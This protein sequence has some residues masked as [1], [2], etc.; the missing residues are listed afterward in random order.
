MTKWLG[1]VAI[2]VLA[3]LAELS[4][5]RLSG[6][7][8]FALFFGRFHPLIVHLPIGFFLLVA[9]GEAATLHPK[10]RQRVEPALGL[11]VPVSALAALAAF[12]MGQL[13]ALEG[14]FPASA[15]GWHR[16]L[17]LLAVIGMS[18]C[19][20]LFDRQ[21]DK[22]GQGRGAYRGV[23]GL[24]LGLLSLGAHFG[25]TMTRGESYLS[26]YAPGPL[27]PL[28]G[29]PEAKKEASGAKP[30]A[31]AAGAE[32]LVYQDVVQPLLTKYC[33]DCH[34]S[35]K[36]KGKLRLDSLE[37]LMAG[38]E[39]GAVV[40][41]GAPSKSLLVTR[42]LLPVADDDHMPPKDEPSPPPEAIALIQ[43]WIERGASA[44]LKVRDALPPATS[45][46]LLEHT[47]NGAA[48]SE[49]VPVSA[50]G[51][52]ARPTDSAVPASSAT[53][54]SSPAAAA[55][56]APARQAATE[57]LN[58][59]DAPPPAPV[60]APPPAT[61]AASSGPAFLAAHCEKCHGSAKQKG[62]LRVDSMAA[63]LKGGAGGAALVPGDPEHSSIVKRVRLALS[64]DE[65]MPPAKEPQPSAAE[66]AALVAWI[67]AGASSAAP[68][69]ASAVAD[70]KS[71][72]GSA[73]SSPA[74]APVE[75][76]AVASGNEPAATSATTVAPSPVAS[77]PLASSPVASS[78]DISGP[79]D[80]QLLSSLPPR[81]LLFA[82]AVQPILRD[83]CGK[84]HI[85]AE[86]AG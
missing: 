72:S 11:L 9:M 44:T 84:C 82:D 12:L 78:P 64:N 62:K 63:L 8:D 47:L 70:A 74:V 71:G 41:A 38:G 4:L 25:G 32:P 55:A 21:H 19:W 68:A 3:V 65:H 13:L 17:T 5:G 83:K 35:E 24:T 61:S 49:A 60:A 40:V 37:L 30:A 20:L 54:P 52:P 16:R 50:P 81:V 15:L 22:A 46:S 6:A 56:S 86:P 67:R 39:D 18:A 75:P 45:R 85:K 58:N 7:P 69:R 34:G 31:A 51:A 80:Q 77:S 23:L 14:G 10:L 2:I 33:V 42:M 29:A 57:T 48:P 76:A 27:K 79:P 66:V 73:S 43:F 1:P 36:Q 53:P 59:D 28:L 26:K